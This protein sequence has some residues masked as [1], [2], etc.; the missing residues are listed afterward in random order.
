MSTPDVPICAVP[1]TATVV[2]LER[3]SVL[4]G[5]RVIADSAHA[6]IRRR[7]QSLWSLASAMCAE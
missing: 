2:V 3:R 5:V 1:T 7:Y 4:G 6:D